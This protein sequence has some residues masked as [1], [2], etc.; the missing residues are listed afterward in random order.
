MSTKREDR[1]IGDGDTLVDPI[2]GQLVKLLLRAGSSNLFTQLKKSLF[3]DE[4]GQLFKGDLDYY[5]QITNEFDQSVEQDITSDRPDMHLL[6]YI[7]VSEYRKRSLRYQFARDEVNKIIE[8][9]DQ[10]IKEVSDRNIE[11]K[12]PPHLV[13]NLGDAQYKAVTTELRGRYCSFAFSFNQ[14]LR[15]GIFFAYKGFL[16]N[17]RATSVTISC[18]NPVPEIQSMINTMKSLNEI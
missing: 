2:T 13:L 11:H 5:D 14:F 7:R 6:K 17:M 4:D 3:I 9:M 1:W 10:A 12:V 8:W 18:G 16:F 15:G